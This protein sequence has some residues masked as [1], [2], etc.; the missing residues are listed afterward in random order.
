M[1]CVRGHEA[2]A[3]L[4]RAVDDAYYELGLPREARE[5]HGHVTLGRVREAGGPLRA[6]TP[7]MTDCGQ[8]MVTEVVLYRSDLLRQGAE[9]LCLAR[10]TL[11]T[12]PQESGQDPGR[13]SGLDPGQ[14]HRGQ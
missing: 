10:H 14:G 2:L 5:F 3:A 9:Y 8:A 6:I 13:S 7:A 1:P 11:G 12:A 4:A